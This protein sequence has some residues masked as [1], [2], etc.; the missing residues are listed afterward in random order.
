MLVL[1]VASIARADLFPFV[2]I[3]GNNPVDAAIGEAQ[4]FVRVI[5][6]GSGQVLFTFINT[7]PEASSITDVYFDDGVLLGI[8][9]IEDSDPGVEF[10]QLAAPQDL[11]GGNLLDPPFV[12]TVGFSADSD[13]AVQPNGVNPGESLGILFDLASGGTFADV[14]SQLHDGTLRIGIRVQGFESGGSES[15]VAV[16]APGAMLL[17]AIGLGAVGLIKRRFA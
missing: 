11:P 16:P 9:S 13:P 17:G 10:S 14:I 8:A 1:V 4:M 6:P 5:D 12:T 2:N 15:F 3:T 7:G